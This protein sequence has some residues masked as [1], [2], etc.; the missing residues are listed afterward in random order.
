MAS[1]FD[2]AGEQEFQ[3]LDNELVDG[4]NFKGGRYFRGK[5]RE[6]SPRRG[7][8]QRSWTNHSQSIRKEISQ[9]TNLMDSGLFLSTWLDAAHLRKSPERCRVYRLLRG[10]SI[11][12]SWIGL[13]HIPGGAQCAVIRR[14]SVPEFPEWRGLSGI[15]KKPDSGKAYI[16]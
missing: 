8:L 14:L 5:S 4:R 9:T 16:S 3:M 13:S 15:E 12:L 2:F 11:C 6:G 7:Q 1:F 10:L